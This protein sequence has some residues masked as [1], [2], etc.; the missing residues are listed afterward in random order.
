MSEELVNRDFF[1]R[2]LPDLSVAEAAP[3]ELTGEYWTPE[4]EGEKRRMFFKEIRQELTT[5]MASGSDVELSVAYFVE[6]VK[7]DKKVIRQAS[8]RLTGVLETLRVE[9]GTPL[10][11]TYLGKK[12]NKTNSFSSDSW[13][14]KPLYIQ[15]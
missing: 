2:Q 15:S 12:K 8:K 1:A 13:S 5:D 3:L 10:E 14:I 6:V 11:I 4:K 9:T 7:G